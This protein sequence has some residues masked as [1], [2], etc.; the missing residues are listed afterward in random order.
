M[1]LHQRGSQC[2]GQPFHLVLPAPASAWADTL[3]SLDASATTS[4]LC[5]PAEGDDRSA[6]NFVSGDSVEGFLDVS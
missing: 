3:D 2:F 1:N 6:I 4:T 5:D